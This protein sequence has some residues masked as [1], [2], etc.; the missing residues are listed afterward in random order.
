[1]N[2]EKSSLLHCSAFEIFPDHTHVSMFPIN[3]STKYWS[4]ILCEEQQSNVRANR[5]Y[6]PEGYGEYWIHHNTLLQRKY[7]CPTGFQYKINEHCMTLQLM[8]KQDN[9]QSSYFF[10]HKNDHC[11]T[12]VTDSHKL[13]GSNHI[14]GQ[15]KY[16]SNLLT[17]WTSFL[18]MDQKCSLT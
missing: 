15:W 1:M 5:I 7:I 11:A 14:L 3:C 10:F 17:Y 8:T 4:R 18:P 12:Y 6:S 13:P 16:Y 2:T 9:K